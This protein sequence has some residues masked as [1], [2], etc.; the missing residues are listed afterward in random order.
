MTVRML[1]LLSPA[2]VLATAA[3][4]K[5]GQVVEH[6]PAPQRTFDPRQLCNSRDTQSLCTPISEDGV[7]IDTN[8]TVPATHA[9]ALG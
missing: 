9:P 7:L 4:V 3:C 1:R 6:R 8:L 5:S 2:L